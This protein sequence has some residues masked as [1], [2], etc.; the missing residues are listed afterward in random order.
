MEDMFFTFAVL[1]LCAITFVFVSA[2]INFILAKIKNKLL[3]I[4]ETEKKD[5]IYIK[6]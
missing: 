1:F 6:K 5:S 4:A 2:Y 3:N